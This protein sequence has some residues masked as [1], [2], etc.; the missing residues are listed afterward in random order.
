MKSRNRR[1]RATNNSRTYQRLRR[2]FK[3]TVPI[4]HGLLGHLSFYSD[5][6]VDLQLNSPIL[7]ASNCGQWGD[8]RLVESVRRRPNATMREIRRAVRVAGCQLV[9]ETLTEHDRWL[10]WRLE[11]RACLL[12]RRAGAYD[13]LDHASAREYVAYVLRLGEQVRSY[14]HRTAAAG[15]GGVYG[16]G[17]LSSYDLSYTNKTL[18]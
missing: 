2:R 14:A 15:D 1:R 13:V 17:R 8:R 10:Y 16:R 4:D 3:R 7:S 12:A 5:V 18:R 9:L 6:L 11:P